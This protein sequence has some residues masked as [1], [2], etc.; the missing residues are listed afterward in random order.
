M[1]DVY[2]RCETFY[3]NAAHPGKEAE[4]KTKRK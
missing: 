2:M 1:Q 4:M 3:G